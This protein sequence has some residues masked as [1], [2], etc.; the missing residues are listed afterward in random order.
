MGWSYRR[1]INL[2]PFRVNLSKNGVGYSI[3][4]GGFR[5][6][7]N[8]QGR[9]YSRVSIPGTGIYY[10]TTKGQSSPSGCLGV[11]LCVVGYGMLAVMLLLF[12]LKGV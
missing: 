2:G 8:A 6:G 12:S 1:A 5:T 9:R 11:I 3:G 4:G 10:T 7:V